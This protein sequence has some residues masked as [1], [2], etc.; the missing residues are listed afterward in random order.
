MKVY[1]VTDHDSA[2]EPVHAGIFKDY[3]SAASFGDTNCNDYDI[4]EFELE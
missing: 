3:V 2:R 1:L 4:E